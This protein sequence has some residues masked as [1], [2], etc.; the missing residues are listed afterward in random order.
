M[1]EQLTELQAFT[2]NFLS[3]SDVL[4]KYSEPLTPEEIE[5][6]C[7]HPEK[8]QN[9][10]GFINRLISDLE[11]L[12]DI[13]E[14]KEQSIIE[15][16]ETEPKKQKSVF[17]TLWEWFNTTKRQLVLTPLGYSVGFAIVVL[18]IQF[19]FLSSPD[20]PSVV[21]QDTFLPPSSSE[22]VQQL[23]NQ[24]DVHSLATVIYIEESQQYGI[25]QRISPKN[26]FKTGILLTDLEVAFHANESKVAITQIDR[27]ISQLQT[28]DANSEVT[29]FYQ[30][31]RQ[32][33]EQGVS[34]TQFIGTSEKADGLFQEK[35]LWLYLRL[36]QWA[37]GG[38][39]ATLI[40]DQSAFD[41]R[42]LQYFTNQLKKNDIP[43]GILEIL[44]EIKEV[45]QTQES[46]NKKFI[47]LQQLYEN[48]I[49]F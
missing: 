8:Y 38:R 1:D 14:I 16:S 33:L 5:D 10:F 11:A 49:V 12:G 43:P 32:R 48:L 39:L 22:M 13:A 17:D 28:V 3:K 37:E 40:K 19:V 24:S 45:I 15:D 27:I 18:F 42:F 46:Q 6:Y 9:D 20:T 2:W 30:D 4:E 41:S 31:I 7:Q 44:N 47:K 21:Q 35:E 36:G 29:S 34:P 26:A 25:S 23:A